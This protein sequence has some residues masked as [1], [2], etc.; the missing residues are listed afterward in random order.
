MSKTTTSRL[1]RKA[2]EVRLENLIYKI[3][4]GNVKVNSIEE[5][6]DILQL[7]IVDMKH[8]LESTKRERDFLVGKLGQG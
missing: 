6:L 5:A 8:D 1:T 2:V 3:G 4:G 7:Y